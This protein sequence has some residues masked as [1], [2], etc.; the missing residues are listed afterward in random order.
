MTALYVKASSGISQIVSDQNTVS[1]STIPMPPVTPHKLVL[2]ENYA[3]CA[4]VLQYS[5]WLLARW[6]PSEIDIIE[7]EHQVLI[8]SYSQEEQRHS[9][10]KDYDDST[11]FYEALCYCQ[12]VFQ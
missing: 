3:F 12:G 5:K 7:Q 2:L 1:D 10:E 4:I 8:N 6:S 11:T 9:A